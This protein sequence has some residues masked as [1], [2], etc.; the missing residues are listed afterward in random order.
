MSV[1]SVVSKQT[2][3]HAKQAQLDGGE[4]E[5]NHRVQNKSRGWTRLHGIDGWMS[6]KRDLDL[7]LDVKMDA[8]HTMTSFYREEEK[9]EEKKREEKKRE[10]E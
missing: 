7:D 6:G 4:Y 1:K 10:R 5:T 3:T 9:R 2:S 8:L